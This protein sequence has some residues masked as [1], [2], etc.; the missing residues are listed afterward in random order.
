MKLYDIAQKRWTE[1]VRGKWVTLPIWS[2]D[3]KFVYYQDFHEPGQPIFRFRLQDSSVE[4]VFS[5]EGL[6]KTSSVRCNFLGLAPDGSLL[7]RAKGRNANLY[8]LQLELP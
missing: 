8:K 2:A 7:I 1:I 6:L 4:R 3:S 5:L